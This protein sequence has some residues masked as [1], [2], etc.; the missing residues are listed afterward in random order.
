LS[1]RTIFAARVIANYD[2]LPISNLDVWGQANDSSARR[3]IRLC[4]PDDTE[5]HFDRVCIDQE[6]RALKGMGFTGC[7]KTPASSSRRTVD[8]TDH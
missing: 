3:Q 8:R 5:L 4:I 6:F 7:G 2:D 1:I